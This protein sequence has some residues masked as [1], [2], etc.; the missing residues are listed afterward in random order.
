LYGLDSAG[1]SLE[2]APASRYALR[3]RFKTG[4]FV[5][6]GP[7][8]AGGYVR[9]QMIGVTRAGDREHVCPLVES[10]GELDLSRCRV[11]CLCDGE[12]LVSIVSGCACFAPFPSDSKVP[13]RD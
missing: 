11:V 6:R 10:P 8:R 1:R 13:V 5:V 12:Y 3:K 7:Q 9:A 4:E 2:R